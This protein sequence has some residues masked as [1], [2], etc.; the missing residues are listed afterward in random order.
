MQLLSCANIFLDFFAI[1]SQN[2]SRKDCRIP[3]T[4]ALTDIA[5][6]IQKR[7]AERAYTRTL[8][9]NLAAI[10]QQTPP[11]NRL[12]LLVLLSGKEFGKIA[13][14]SRKQAVAKKYQCRG[15]TGKK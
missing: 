11:E 2:H 13:I 9:E 10:Y 6:S 1:Y 14:L 4:E 3:K 5:M 8:S 12:K 7:E 15:Q